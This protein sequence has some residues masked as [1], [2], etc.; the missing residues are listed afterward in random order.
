V[1]VGITNANYGATSTSFCVWASVC[2]PAFV[3]CLDSRGS[4]LSRD[5]VSEI[6]GSRNMGTFRAVCVMLQLEVPSS[7]LSC[8]TS[9]IRHLQKSTENAQSGPS[10]IQKRKY[11]TSS[12]HQQ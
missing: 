6:V 5:S 8:V 1:G 4:S 7:V 12:V 10:Q 3:F 2:T 11:S 9:T